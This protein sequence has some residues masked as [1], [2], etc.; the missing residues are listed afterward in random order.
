MSKG[1]PR[2]DRAERF[3]WQ[4]GDLKRVGDVPEK[5]RPSADPDR[6]LA[7][8]QAAVDA[9]RQ[10]FAE[11]PTLLKADEARRPAFTRELQAAV[12]RGRPLSDAALHKAVGLRPPPAGV[13]I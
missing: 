10:R 13:M 5:E 9:Y 7:A 8:F 3:L 11:L 1:G 6:E 2:P 12:A 4:K